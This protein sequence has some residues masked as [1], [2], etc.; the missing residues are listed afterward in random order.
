M[1]PTTLLDE[2]GQ[3]LQS[4]SGPINTIGN[5]SPPSPLASLPV[6]ELLNTLGGCCAE[7]LNRQARQ[8]S[9]SLPKKLDR[10]GNALIFM[11]CAR[12]L[13]GRYISLS[14]NGNEVTASL[15]CP[16]TILAE[17]LGTT[18]QNI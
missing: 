15:E 11:L 7:L 4:G 2:H 10:R 8:G 6:E 1:C 17:A 5:L 9:L 16:D 12:V 14:V 3:P 18:S 13:G